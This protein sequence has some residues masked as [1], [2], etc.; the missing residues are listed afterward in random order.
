MME[1]GQIGPGV[2]DPNIQV[3]IDMI[4]KMAITA[5]LIL[6]LVPAFAMA[7]GPQGQGD[8]SAT[9]ENGLQLQQQI[10]SQEQMSTQMQN[11][12]ED[13]ML[14][15]R[16]CTQECLRSGIM[17]QSKG[18]LQ[19]GSTSGLQQDQTRDMTWDRIRDRSHLQDGSCGT[20]PTLTS[21]ISASADQQQDQTHDMT[22]DRIRGRSH[23]QDGSCGNCQNL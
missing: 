21:G 3:M 23:L 15:N 16:F 14:Q 8:G 20:C 7:A 19:L 6:I 4:K 10:S 12:G 22:W 2:P 9:Q 5:V 1:T 18:T 11:S 17:T 13:Q